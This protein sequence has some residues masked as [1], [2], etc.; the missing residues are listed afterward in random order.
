M[1]TQ[2]SHTRSQAVHFNSFSYQLSKSQTW[3]SQDDWTNWR[4]GTEKGVKRPS[5]L[6]WNTPCNIT[7]QLLIMLIQHLPRQ[8]YTDFHFYSWDSSLPWLSYDLNSCDL[9]L[10][11]LGYAPPV[12]RTDKVF[13]MSAGMSSR[14]SSN[15]PGCLSLVLLTYLVLLIFLSCHISSYIIRGVNFFYLSFYLGWCR[16]KD[17]VDFGLEISP[18]IS[19]INSVNVLHLL[20]YL[21]QTV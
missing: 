2:W 9:Q 14:L 1:T 18:T 16:L 12:S 6:N 5:T 21:C 7:Y 4:N 8:F 19:I 17:H 3:A 13:W 10:Y 11:I 15:K 20:L